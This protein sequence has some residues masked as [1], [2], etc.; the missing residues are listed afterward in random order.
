[1]Q[2]L[3]HLINTKTN[4]HLSIYEDGRVFGNKYGELLVVLNEQSKRDILGLIRV[5]MYM[6]KT[7][8][9]HCEGLNPIMMNIRDDSRKHR[10][11]KVYGWS[12]IPLLLSYIRNTESLSDISI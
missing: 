8:T 4:Q 3:I 5:N 1:M 11:I 9:T 6:F 2:P 7:L 10:K 12:Q